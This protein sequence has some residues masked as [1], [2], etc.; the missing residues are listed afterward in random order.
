MFCKVMTYSLL[1]MSN[2]SLLVYKRSQSIF[3]NV[4]LKRT[5][6]I[7]TDR[8]DFPFSAILGQPDVY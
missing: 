5:Y 8:W 4:R 2:E 3:E 7:C 6:Q 1:C